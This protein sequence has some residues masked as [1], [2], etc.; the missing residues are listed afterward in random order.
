MKRNTKVKDKG[1]DDEQ[2]DQLQT[3]DDILED[4]ESKGKEVV[5]SNEQRMAE[6]LADTPVIPESEV[7]P[8]AYIFSTMQDQQ[9]DINIYEEK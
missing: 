1:S 4:D 3:T 9:D 2:E 5:I 8:A 6:E 7:S